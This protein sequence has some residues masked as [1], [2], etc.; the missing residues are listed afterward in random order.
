MPPIVR[1]EDYQVDLQTGELRK[2]GTKI[3]LSGQPFQILALLLEKPGE[4]ITR[5]ELRARLWPDEVFIDFDHSLN[6][7]VNKLREA[8]GDSTN[9][10]HFVE[11]LPKR[12]YRFI[13]SIE[14]RGESTAGESAAAIPS[15]PI[16]PPPT[17]GRRLARHIALASAVFAALGLVAWLGIVL[18]RPQRSA[19][20][21]PPS[22]RSIAILPFTNLSGDAE[23][24]YFAD[25]LT[26]EF[27]AELSRISSLRV[28]SR[29][30]IMQYKT[31]IH[32][33]LSQIAEELH[34]DAVLEGSV[35][36]SGNRVRIAAHMIYGPTDQ[37]LLAETY[38]RDLGDVLKLQREVAEAVAKQVRLK[39]VPA[40]E[41]RMDQARAVNPE[42]YDNYLKGISFEPT[43]EG[44]IKKAKSHFEIAIQ[45]DPDFAPAYVGLARCY[46]NL[47]QFGWLSPRE[48][49]QPSKQAALAALKLDETNCG[50]HW[51]LAFVAWNYDW[52]WQT[53]EKELGYALERCPNSA[54]MREFH[55]LYLAWSGQA[56]EAQ[57]EIV[58]AHEL[59][60]H[61]SELV[62]YETVLRYHVRDYRSMM[63]LSH[64]EIETNPND[65]MA[66]YL[67][68]VGHEGS[69]HIAEAIPEYR[70]A[71]ELSGGGQDSIS[72]L[73][74]A[75]AATGKKADAEKILSEWQRQPKTKYVSTYMTA[76]IYAGLGD[77]DST[78]KYL[79]R[80]YQE[81]SP[82]LL[83]FLRADPRMDNLRTDPRFQDLLRRMNFPR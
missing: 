28:T 20:V 42:A 68:G 44:E 70:K 51:S 57:S 37:H 45:K 18:L 78:F 23:Q 62:R 8:L 55:A 12:G 77:K 81:R 46:R 48:A 22:I 11:T 65:W 80:A 4:L 56:V 26:D 53:A 25:G 21:G 31:E 52:D 19:A 40:R 30:S 79:E 24:E 50:A 10:S 13:G 36:R 1:F 60:P 2:N 71:V 17:Q 3:R 76:T 27:I 82:D 29:T 15:A 41:I 49:Y 5:E 73:A 63:E 34:V 54:A 14:V 9:D 61:A 58:R 66:H 35:L 59:D 83:Y 16:L 67:L 7:A 32:K 69:G 64:R 72:A 74:H 39:V 6:T 47:G 43:R 38:E 75:Y 33:P